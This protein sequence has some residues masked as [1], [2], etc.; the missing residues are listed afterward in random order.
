MNL[1]RSTSTNN[2]FFF[3]YKRH[4]NLSTCVHLWELQLKELPLKS[5]GES[6][7]RLVAGSSLKDEEKKCHSCAVEEDVKYEF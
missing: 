4:L 3:K 1:L 6:V 2:A 5:A 7:N